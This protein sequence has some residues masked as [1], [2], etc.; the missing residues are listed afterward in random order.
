MNPQL[1]T[2]GRSPYRLIDIKSTIQK[3][4]SLEEKGATAFAATP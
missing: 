4:Y 3:L 1:S 2:S